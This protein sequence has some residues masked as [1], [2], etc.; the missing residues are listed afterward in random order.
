MEENTTKPQNIL[1]LILQEATAETKIGGSLVL[2]NG[3]YFV[4]TEDDVLDVGQNIYTKKT[5]GLLLNKQDN[6]VSVLL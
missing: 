3:Y 2:Q 4:T 5:S 1:F 6:D